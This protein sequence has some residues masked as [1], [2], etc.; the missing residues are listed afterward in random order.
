MFNLHS[1]QDRIRE[2]DG[3]LF[4][5]HHRRDPIAYRILGLPVSAHAT[6][7]WFYWVPAAGEP[8]KL[9]NRIEAGIL[10]S[11]P[12]RKCEYAT[13]QELHERLVEMLAGVRKIAMQYSPMNMLPAVS[14]VDAGTIEMLRGFGIEIVSSA[15]LVQYFEARW[16]PEQLEMHREA[17]RRVD[18]VLDSAFAHIGD[19][20][21]DDRA[22]TEFD[23]AEFI[24]AQFA[25]SGL[26]TDHG[27]IVA[28]N[29][30]A[31]DPHYEPAATGSAPIRSGD[32]VLIDLWAKLAQAHAVY[33][34]ITWVAYCGREVPPVIQHV[35]DVVRSARDRA[36]ETIQS[37][38]RS[39]R[40]IAGWE[41]DAAARAHIEAA[42]YGDRFTH[43][44]GHSIGEDIHG[45]GANLDGYETRDTRLLIPDTCCSI[46]PGIYL[47][48][49]GV[50]SE[51][52]C[53]VADRDAHATGRVQNAIVLIT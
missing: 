53:F 15:D 24:R 11:L 39:G 47:P 46:E 22:L 2:T 48:E 41:A 33:Y 35:F 40:A 51:I 3:W 21:R 36:L 32:F 31:G 18:Q 6:R 14:M 9:V 7:R 23:V 29:A 45:A 27:P 20:L 5:D 42:G 49:F 26:Y 10:D 44:L 50:R 25:R 28:V 43:R 16:T 19:A 37:A 30:H 8:V 13:W 17:G 4:Y 34:D 38:C 1:I 52:D 12:G